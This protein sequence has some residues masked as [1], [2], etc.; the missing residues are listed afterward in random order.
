MQTYTRTG[1]QSKYSCACT[2]HAMHLDPRHTYGT[3]RQD[4]DTTPGIS[5]QEMGGW[6]EGTFPLKKVLRL[7]LRF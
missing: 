6:G 3:G 5:D 7:H 4:L 1:A 2:S